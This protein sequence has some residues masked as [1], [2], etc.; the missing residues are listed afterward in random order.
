MPLNI[1][2][3]LRTLGCG[4]CCVLARGRCFLP[5]RLDSSSADFFTKRR[6]KSVTLSLP[7]CG[8]SLQTSVFS[9]LHSWDAQRT[10]ALGDFLTGICDCCSV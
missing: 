10:V 8:S 4:I 5:R 9:G 3:G 6:G 2:Q 7:R 1:C